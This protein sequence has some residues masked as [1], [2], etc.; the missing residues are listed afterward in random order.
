MTR[1]R[2]LL[3]AGLLAGAAAMAAPAVA[4]PLPDGAVEVLAGPQAPATGYVTQ[5]VFSTAGSALT[6]TNLDTTTHDVT[7]RATKTV[8]VK[9][10]KRQR[11][12]FT[13]GANGGGS[14]T[15]A[16]TKGLKPGTYAFFCS[17]HPGM[18]GTL[19]VQ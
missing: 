10:K 16:S 18:T 4:Q 15:I 2:P 14:V 6:L 13:G 5:Q 7:S 19:P 9:G 8:I 12:L 3:L 1:P 11:P 17:L